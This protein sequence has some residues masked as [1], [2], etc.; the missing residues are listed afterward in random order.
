MIKYIVYPTP[1]V[2][3]LSIVRFHGVNPHECCDASRWEDTR[4]RDCSK[5]IALHPDKS[6]PVPVAEK[7]AA[8]RRRFKKS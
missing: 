5:L 2:G 6:R 3:F 8:L 4:G 1:H 7:I